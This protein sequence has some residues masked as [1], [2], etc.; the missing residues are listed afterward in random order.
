MNPNEFVMSLQGLIQSQ[1]ADVHTILPVKITSVDYSKKTANV[2]PLVK[3]KIGVS[4]SVAYPELA[5]VPLV[6]L[7][8]GKARITFPVKAGD[9]GIVLFSERDVSN[10]LASTGTDTVEPLMSNYLGLFPIA[11]ICG[12]SINSDSEEISNE[13]IVIENELSKISLKPDG[14]TTIQNGSSSIVQEP[15]GNVR[16][17]GLTVTPDG[18]IITASGVNLNEFY[19]KFMSH[20]HSG[21]QRGGSNTDTLV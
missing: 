17:N 4:K 8:G 21:V 2:L 14:T 7:S 10:V 1:L 16:V 3:T 12:I 15:N 20:V 5:G 11:V 13:D 9:T 18:N 6:V 19:Q